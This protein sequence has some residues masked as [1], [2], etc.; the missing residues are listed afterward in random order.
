[1]ALSV[2]CRTYD[3]KVVGSSLGRARGAKTLGKFVTPMCL[4]SPSSISCYRP[5]G[6]DAMRLE[7][8][9][10]VCGWQVKLCD[11]PVKH[12]PYLSALEIR[13]GIKSTIEMVCLL[14]FTN[15]GIKSSKYKCKQDNVQANSE[16]ETSRSY[17]HLRKIGQKL[18]SLSW[19]KGLCGHTDTQ[20]HRHTLK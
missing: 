12:M 13:V 5:K 16:S 17:C 19:T 7:S 8:K 15:R 18:R 2:E 9:G 20:T 6:G 3:Q 4:C 11:P 10:S 14:F 1:M